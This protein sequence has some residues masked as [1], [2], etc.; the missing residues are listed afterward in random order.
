MT[1]LITLSVAILICFGG[2][3]AA[4]AYIEHKRGDD[5]VLR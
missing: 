4:V 5:D 3:F 2:P 1:N